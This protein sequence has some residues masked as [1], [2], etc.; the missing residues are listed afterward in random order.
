M[1]FAVALSLRNHLW[2]VTGIE[3]ELGSWLAHC[4]IL[5]MAEWHMMDCRIFLRWGSVVGYGSIL[6]VGNHWREVQLGSVS[7]LVDVALVASVSC[8]FVSRPF[9]RRMFVSRL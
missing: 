7:L 5:E 1:C 9:E 8:G 6:R 3:G 4:M 2:H